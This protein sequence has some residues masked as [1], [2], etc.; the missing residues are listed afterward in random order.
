MDDAGTMLAWPL[1]D[2][3][4]LRRLGLMGLLWLALHLPLG[5]IPIAAIA[6]PR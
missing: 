4:W 3:R 2:P 6:L 5:G 1:Q